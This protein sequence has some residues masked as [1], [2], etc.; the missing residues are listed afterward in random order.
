MIF[1]LVFLGGYFIT[2][3]TFKD[4]SEDEEELEDSLS[5]YFMTLAYINTLERNYPGIKYM[6][7]EESFEIEMV[8]YY[9]VPVVYLIMYTL[10]V[11]GDH[12]FNLLK[13]PSYEGDRNLNTYE[14]FRRFTQGFID[15]AL[16]HAQGCIN[17]P[18]KPYFNPNT[19]KVYRS[20]CQ[21][22]KQKTLKMKE[23][24]DERVKILGQHSNC[25]DLSESSCPEY[26][27]TQ[28]KIWDKIDEFL[29]ES[30]E[31]FSRCKECADRI[32]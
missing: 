31:L 9:K 22:I 1:V 30:K 23:L 20:V 12:D 32:S 13:S 16:D 26:Y 4:F 11:I 3:G 6:F 25:Q 27:E 28:Q 29:D 2:G 21:V 17:V 14:K 15:K 7:W 8:S 24:E 5:H 19:Y 10:G 18:Q